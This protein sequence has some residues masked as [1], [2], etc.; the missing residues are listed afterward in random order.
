MLIVK[1]KKSEHLETIPSASMQRYAAEIFRIEQ[2]HEIV[3][4]SQL[5][6]AIDA[7]HQAIANMVHRLSKAGYTDFQAYKG[8]RLTVEGKKIAMNLL[9]RHRIGEVFFVD[10]MGYDWA[11]AH[12]LADNFEKGIN[13]E[14]EDRL[15]EMTGDPKYCPHGEPIPDREGQISYLDD[16]RLVDEEVGA[17][18]RL[19]RVR[20]HNLD[21]LQYLGKLEM[22][23]GLEFFLVSKAPFRGP[24]RMR[25]EVSDRIIGYELAS[26]LWAEKI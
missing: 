2:D 13:A 10:V 6:S 1:N 25:F 11:Q 21:K 9:R 16:M 5:A 18:Y 19:T 17:N 8:V 24:L 14:L 23:P 3:S 4:L 15:A 20:T 26:S 7:S 12:L 22:K